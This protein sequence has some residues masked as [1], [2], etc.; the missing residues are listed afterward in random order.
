MFGAAYHQILPSI[1]AF[2]IVLAKIEGFVSGQTSSPYS[3]LAACWSIISIAAST[4]KCHPFGL[5]HWGPSEP[6]MAMVRD[7]NIQIMKD[8]SGLPDDEVDVAQAEFDFKASIFLVDFS[9][10]VSS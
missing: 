5:L 1:D 2:A 4:S 8:Q 10:Y 9:E 6:S 3:K 7:D